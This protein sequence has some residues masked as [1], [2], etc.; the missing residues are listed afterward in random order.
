VCLSGRT[1]D[2]SLSLNKRIDVRFVVDNKSQFHFD[3]N[4]AVSLSLHFIGTVSIKK[5]TQ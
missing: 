3:L 4:I 5:L 2:S 1:L